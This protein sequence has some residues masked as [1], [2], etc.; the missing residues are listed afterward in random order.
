M[1]AYNKFAVA[2][3]DF[4]GTWTSDFTGLQQ[5]YNVYTGDYAGMYVNQSNETFEFSPGGK[6]NWKLLVVSGM[7]GAS[8][9]AQVKSS[10]KLTVLNNWQI[11]FSEIENRPRKYHAYFSCIKGARLLHLL[12][13]DYP[14]SGIYTVYGKK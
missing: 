8:K 2:A 10:G 1:Q 12:D 11:N 9:F 3:S 7:A 13:A 6:Y 5:L 4:S 14:G